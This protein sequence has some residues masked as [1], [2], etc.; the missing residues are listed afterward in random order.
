MKAEYR[1][2]EYDGVFQIQRKEFKTKITGMLWWIKITKEAKWSYVD[3]WGTCL[4]YSYRTGLNNYKRKED[5]F[6]DLASALA[7]IEIMIKGETYHYPK[8][9]K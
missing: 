5:P 1:V 8:L 6:N 3:K 2:E 4:W 9:N 7:K